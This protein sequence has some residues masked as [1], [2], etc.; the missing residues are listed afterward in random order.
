[1]TAADRIAADVT[2]TRHGTFRVLVAATFC[3]TLALAPPFLIGALS[4]LNRDELGLGEVRLGVAV[5]VYFAASALFSIPGGRI[6]ERIGPAYAVNLATAIAATSMLSIGSLVSGF[7]GLLASLVIGGMSNGISQ[8][9]GNL[10]ISRGVPRDRQG[11]AF[12]IKQSA[13][14]FATLLSGLSVGLLALPFGWRVPFLVLTPVLLLPVLVSMPPVRD[15][16]RVLG[17][18]HG[19]ESLRGRGLGV[20]AVAAVCVTATSGTLGVFLVESGVAIGLGPAAAGLVLSIGSTAGVVT[21]LIGGWL[22]D[23][24][25]RRPFVA[26]T[27]LLGVGV[28]GFLSLASNSAPVFVLGALVAFA[29][30]WGWAGLFVLGVVRAFPR[31]PARAT[32]VTQT[33]FSTGNVVGPIAFGWLVAATSFRTAW[34]A[35]AVTAAVGTVLMWHGARVV[36]RTGPAPEGAPERLG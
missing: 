20:L 22:A 7:P 32:G 9:A 34:L 30:G 6:A 18:R 11:L 17:G 29:A 28:L 2:P 8:P 14:L 10:A 12:G 19:R 23:H 25:L 24:G 35:A 13:I 15:G 3:N 21:R 5:A 36:T 26:V 4:V 16:Q 31:T 33:G 1:M 27:A